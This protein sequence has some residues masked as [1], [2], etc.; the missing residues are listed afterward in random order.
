[1]RQAH[2]TP[3]PHPT[4]PTLSLLPRHQDSGAGDFWVSRL[5]GKWF[6]GKFYPP[7]TQ[8]VK[9]GLPEGETLEWGEV[10]SSSKI[11]VGQGDGGGVSRPG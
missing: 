1:M 11:R 7:G 5:S 9:E 8:G 4:F 10:A 3:F 6:G 2:S